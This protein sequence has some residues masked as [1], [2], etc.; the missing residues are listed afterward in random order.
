MEADANLLIERGGERGGVGKG[1]LSPDPMSPDVILRDRGEGEEGGLPE[2]DADESEMF[3]SLFSG[4]RFA[5]EH[6]PGIDTF[7]N[8]SDSSGMGG[9]INAISDVGCVGRVDEVGGM[10]AGERLHVQDGNHCSWL[11]GGG[12][13]GRRGG[14]GGGAGR[15]AGEG[16]GGGGGDGKC[17][18]ELGRGLAIARN[19]VEDGGRAAQG[20]PAGGSRT[21][22]KKV[23][24]TVEELERERKRSHLRKCGR[25]GEPGHT[26]RTC[27][28]SSHADGQTALDRDEPCARCDRPMHVHE[29]GR[30]CSYRTTM[31][32]APFEVKAGK[33]A[34]KAKK[35]G[36]KDEGEGTVTGKG[37]DNDR[38]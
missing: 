2:L 37:G 30:E 21:K 28:S 6:I 14:G 33:G 13:G 7:G 25:C 24:L 32:E 17:G 19:A 1:R 11:G 9:G 12:G 35:G 38:R 4:D 5:V 8:A 10:G 23:V 27:V 22:R 31:N 18:G 36:R 29:E 34:K 16:G 3:A 26:K 15:G 20:G